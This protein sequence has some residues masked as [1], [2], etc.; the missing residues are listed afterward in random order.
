MQEQQVEAA[1]SKLAGAFLERVQRGLVAVVADPPRGLDEH[2]VSRDP[3]LAHPFS[4]LPLIGVR[5]GGVDEPIAASNGRFDGGDRL[6][7]CALEYDEAD[8]RYLHAVV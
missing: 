7:R 3:R 5:R 1:D 6:L 8:R 2:L 4:D